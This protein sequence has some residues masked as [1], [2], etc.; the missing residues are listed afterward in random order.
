[1]ITTGAVAG[2][3]ATGGLAMP[4]VVTFGESMALFRT[5][6]AETLRTARRFTRSIAGAESNVA[7]GLSRLGFEAGWFGRVGDDPLGLSILDALRA[8]GV[9][10]S[11]AI[12]D[13]AAPTGVL[14]RDTHAERRIDVVYAR[15]E[16]AGSRL[17]PADIDGEYLAS[18]RV[19]H[20]TGITPALSP[21]ARAA[22]AAAVALAAEAGVTVCFD[23]N[24]RRRLW[25]DMAE[26][27]RA[28]LPLIER[29]QIVLLG[30]AEATLLTGT[31]DPVAAAQWLV[32]HGVTTI[33]VKL[34]AD[35]ALGLRDDDSYHGTALNVHPADPIGA[36]DAFDAGFL[37]AWLGGLALSDCIDD[38][39]LAA[40]LSIQVCG[41]IEGLPYRREMDERRLNNLEAN[42]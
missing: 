8:E 33:A 21:S 15:A 26:A 31:E 4:D 39:N 7:I 20:I 3:A 22:T 1:L 16:S 24:L 25:P 10:V 37:S 40:G 17:S 23:P 19:L 5:D 42:R 18:A 36:G 11:R 9:D 14:V 41:D 30:R 35:G 27:R 32:Q 6:P 13:G 2:V 38:G 28:L 29:S 12:V 34:G